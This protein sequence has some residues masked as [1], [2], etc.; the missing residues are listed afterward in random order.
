MRIRAALA[1]LIFAALLHA[2]GASAQQPKLPPPERANLKYGPHERNVIDVWLAKAKAPTPLVIYIHGGGFVAGDKNTLNPALLRGCLDAGISVAAINYRYST[3][4][5]FPAPFMDSARAVQFLRTQ[6]KDLNLDPTRFGATGGSAGAGMSLWLG[7]HDDLADPKSDDP[8]LRESTRLRCMA[9]MGAQTS[10]DPR[11]IRKVVGGR[12]DQHPAL[13]KL[14]GLAPDE[15]DSPR[16]HEMYEAASP[17]NFVTA[18]DPPVWLFYSEAD[19]PLPADAV[20]GQGIHHPNFG[21]A[22]KEKM[23]PLKIECLVRQAGEKGAGPNESVEFFV[24]NLKAVEG[25]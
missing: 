23:D 11:F 4:A 6:A 24:K 12:A 14:Y 21:K 13:A 15:L 8:V 7:F 22:L 25:K 10:Y 17:I 5:P 18:D 20:P 2:S 16:A 19:A 3:Q 1:A 9:V